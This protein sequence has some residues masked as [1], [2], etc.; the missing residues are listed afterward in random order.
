MFLLSEAQP[1][2]ALVNPPR[3]PHLETI[4]THVR[5]RPPPNL[6]PPALFTPA[7]Q[8]ILQYITSF[9]NFSIIFFYN[10][11]ASLNHR[12]NACSCLVSKLAFLRDNFK[13]LRHRLV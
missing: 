9:F 6:R 13:V 5:A 10:F 12:A 2:N 1:K 3:P 8:F 7:Q 4:A 11:Q